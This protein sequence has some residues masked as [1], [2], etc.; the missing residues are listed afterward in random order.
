[1]DDRSFLLDDEDDTTVALQSTSGSPHGFEHDCGRYEGMKGDHSNL[2]QTRLPFVPV[3]N[4]T[5]RFT[6]NSFL[7]TFV[8]CGGT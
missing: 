2:E 5:V 1:M 8:Y 6:V 3:I 7:N 4:V